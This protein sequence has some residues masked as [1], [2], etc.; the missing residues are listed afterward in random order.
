MAV[1]IELSKVTFLLHV[2]TAKSFSFTEAIFMQTAMLQKILKF[3]IVFLSALFI[4]SFIPLCIA[5]L[6]S[7]LAYKF[8]VISISILVVLCL[9]LRFQAISSRALKYI[10]AAII[11]GVILCALSL[12]SP[13]FNFL[14]TFPFRQ[15]AV[16]HFLKTHKP[17]QENVQI[18]NVLLGETTGFVYSNNTSV[19]FRYYPGLRNFGERAFI[20]FTTDP[21]TK[22]KNKQ[23]SDHMFYKQLK[24][25]WF[26]IVTE[27]SPD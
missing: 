2:V 12:V 23:R 14:L 8:T 16:N 18:K 4:P 3:I 22:I 20:L 25:N 6:F 10:L 7:Y 24:K 13:E 27:P 11:G 21:I 1:I 5:G 17:V 26:F 15:Q 9:I 19:Y